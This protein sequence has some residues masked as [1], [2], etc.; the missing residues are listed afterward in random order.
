MNDGQTVN[1]TATG[2]ITLVE[3]AMTA[4]R[5][6]IRD[7]DLKVGDALPGEGKFA[8]DLEVSR[9]VMREA[10]GALAALRQIDVANGRRARVA[11][12]DGS[13]MASSLDHAVA[14]AQVS[15]VDVWDVR[16]TLELRT[17]GL[18]AQNR[19][20]AQA[21]QIMA[22]AEA[23][24][25]AAGDLARLSEAD[26]EFHHAIAEAS[27]NPLFHQI[28]RSFNRLMDVAVPRAWQTRQTDGQRLEML[29][30]HRDVARAI[31]D[32]DTA[33]AVA[34]MDRHFDT[35]IADLMR[36]REPN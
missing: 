22:A 36:M 12:I 26:V 29:E 15:V 19:S 34:L 30:L 23:M 27:G 1:Q 5:D 10:F 3:R 33:R 14:T 28:V 4:V 25:E 8:A 18:A 2:K 24:T 13:V 11:A 9:A 17:V 7:N 32:R 21:R 20:E 16:R 6:Y 35:S 31:A